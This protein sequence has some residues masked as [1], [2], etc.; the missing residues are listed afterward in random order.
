MSKF[1]TIRQTA[2][3]PACPLREGTLRRMQKQGELPGF[4]TG[5][6]FYVNF[7]LLLEMLAERSRA[8]VRPTG[9]QE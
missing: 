5:T 9:A 8:S 3:D 1:M 4:F 6:R 2:A 7:D